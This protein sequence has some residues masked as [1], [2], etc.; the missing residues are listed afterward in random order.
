MTTN[1]FYIYLACSLFFSF[2]LGM[3]WGTFQTL[4]VIIAMPLLQ[5][6]VPANVTLIFKGFNDIVN[7][8]IVDPNLVKQWTLS[9]IS[10]ARNYTDEFFGLQNS[11]QNATRLLQDDND[12]TS[13][14]IL[15]GLGLAILIV[16]V[17]LT[18]LC[19]SFCLPK[20]PCLRSIFLKIK[21]KLMWSAPLRYITTSY[22]KQAIIVSAAISQFTDK[23]KKEQAF[24]VIEFAYLILTPVLIYLLLRK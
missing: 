10:N 14:F 20:I 16:L 9:T 11:T 21:Y 2:A 12:V 23:D 19:Y 6:L 24:T 3:L 8:Q 5:V 17:L 18:V 7:L 22:L 15:I 1:L 4:Q 13:N